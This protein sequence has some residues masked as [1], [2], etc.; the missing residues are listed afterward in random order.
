MYYHNH[1]L[2]SQSEV[3]SAEAEAVFLLMPNP[4]TTTEKQNINTVVNAMVLSGNWA[5]MDYFFF[6]TLTDEANSLMCAI[7]GISASNVNG[8]VHTPNQGFRGNGTTK[9]IDTNFNLATDSVNATLNINN[10]GAYCYDNFDVL[11]QNLFG[12]RAGLA[13]TGI[14]QT[15]TSINYVN[16]AGTGAVYAP[17]NV[18]VKG[19][20]STHRIDSV[21]SYYQENG[22]T[23]SSSTVS[24]YGIPA[25][26]MGILAQKYTSITGH[27]DGTVSYAYYGGNLDR[28]ALNNELNLLE[29]LFIV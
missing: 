18:F 12:S 23:V 27:L 28:V 21:N 9:Y 13:F 1:I 11:T 17:S 24:S 25:E 14:V 5:K 7:R 22:V 3:Y 16:N 19:R 10:I 29:S 15:G 4:L 20:Y 2:R 6:N 26:T 8:C